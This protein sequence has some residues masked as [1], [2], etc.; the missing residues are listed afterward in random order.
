[1]K[2]YF[3]KIKEKNT[4]RYYVGCQYGK[5]SDPKN[6]WV[7]YFTSNKYVKGQPKNSFVVVYLKERADAREYE[8]RYLQKCYRMLGKE[9]FLSILINRNIAPG[10]LNTPE[11]IAKANTIKK[12]LKNS[13][14]AK[15]RF[16]DGTHN[17][18]TKRH[19]PTTEQRVKLSQRMKN[20]NYGSLIDRND[21]YRKK[22][23]KNSKGNTNVKGK[24]WWYNP[25]TKERKRCFEQPGK[26]WLNTSPS[27]I[28]E[29]GRQKISSANKKEKSLEHKQKLSHKAKQRV[30]NKTHNFLK[31]NKIENKT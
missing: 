6:F 31:E 15:K 21:E 3:Y 19:T 30:E 29:E 5:K 14:A 1:M 27:C 28:S 17:F 8:K 9:K 22:Q 16:K 25:Q 10:I 2:P 4:G 23:A 26:E 18:L 20:N 24:K 11:S 7:S 12:R 13:A